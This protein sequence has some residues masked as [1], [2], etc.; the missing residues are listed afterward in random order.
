LCLDLRLVYPPPVPRRETIACLATL[1]A[2]LLTAPGLLRVEFDTSNESFFVEGDPTL[3]A[4]HEFLTAFGSD[5]VVYALVETEGVF[6]PGTLDD[7]LALG[8]ELSALDH[9]LEVHSPLHSR[10]THEEDGALVGR[11]LAEAA[12]AT[13]DALAPWIER[14]RGHRP[15]RGLLLDDDARHVGFL[16]RLDPEVATP[17]GRAQVADDL[18]RLLSDPRWAQYPH[19]AVG[20]PLNATLFAR[21]LVR[22]MIQA[23][24]WGVGLAGVLLWILF[25]DPRPLLAP[26]L[27]ILAS[28]VVTLGTMGWLGVPLSTVSTILVTLLI[29]VGVAD[30]MHVSAGVQRHLAAGQSPPEAIRASVREA[31][32]PCLLTSVT[33]SLGFLALLSSDIAPVRHLGVFAALGALAAFVATFGLAPLCL[34]GWRSA[35]SPAGPA[36]WL[37]R[38]QQV[39]LRR[40]GA[41]ALASAALLAATGAGLARLY[42]EH[43]FLAYLDPDEPLRQQ[44]EFVQARMGGAVA[45]ELVVDTGEADGVASAAVLGELDAL[46]ALARDLNPIVRSV[47]S[48]TDELREVHHVLGGPRALPDSDEALAELLLTWQLADPDAYAR[49]VSVDGAR[50]R[51]TLR[52]DV[53]GSRRYQVVLDALDAELAQRFPGLVRAHLTGGAVLLARMKDYLLATQTRSFLLALAVV[54][55]LVM[56]VAGSWRLGLLTLIPNLAPIAAVLGVMGWLGIAVEVSNVLLATIAIGIV[57]D[58]TI[59]VVHRYRLRRAE[60]DVR[61]AL[62]QTLN[63]SGRAVLFTSLVLIAAFSVYAGS[64]LS[65]VRAF[66]LLAAATF[67]AALVADLLLLPALIVL[68]D[69]SEP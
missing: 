18:A 2:V 19:A 11:S 22:E 14:V 59:H 45:V 44:L 55:P 57:V 34:R 49:R 62:E 68:V 61:A 64:A 1:V 29:C 25:R 52:L 35:R 63:S 8:H 69:R 39:P 24:G 67:L 27:V 16:V 38:L 12:P 7:M 54:A 30:A 47:R 58:D 41:T 43:D 15:F 36:R 66:G 48:P 53:V 17:R 33:T 46:A 20:T 31:W 13:P 4:Y 60:T 50:A 56:L 5:E 21:L 6:A 40:P 28:L 37:R 10:V 65:N 42:A 23:F 3:S 26:A 51:L 32:R 9:V